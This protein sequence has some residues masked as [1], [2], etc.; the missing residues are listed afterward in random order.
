MQAVNKYWDLIINSQNQARLLLNQ[1]D[2][3]DDKRELI[4]NTKVS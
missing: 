1:P 4:E 3:S 2:L